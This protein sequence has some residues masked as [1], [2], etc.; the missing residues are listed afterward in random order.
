LSIDLSS[1]A[2]ASS[3]F[4]RVFSASSSFSRFASALWT[5]QFGA[6]GLDRSYG[7]S[8]DHFGNIYSVGMTDGPLT[9]QLELT[10]FR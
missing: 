3:F 8:I 9:C 5:D 4:N 1:S 7:I 6:I 10:H 2:S